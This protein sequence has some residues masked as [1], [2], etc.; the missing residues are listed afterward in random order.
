[1]MDIARTDLVLSIRRTIVP[2]IVGFILAQGARWGFDIPPSD[3][4]G[5]IESL[6][7]GVYYTLV[8][9]AETYWPQ[10]GVLLGGRS[11]P[12]YPVHW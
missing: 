4:T 8:R 12:E 5:V 9:L 2:L 6:V 7:T 1:M 3:L 10:L 11:Q